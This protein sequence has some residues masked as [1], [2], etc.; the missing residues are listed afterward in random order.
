M[1][2]FLSVFSCKAFYNKLIDS[3]KCIEVWARTKHNDGFY[4]YKTVE[5][6]NKHI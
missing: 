3:L 4:L 6:N 1:I 5:R 2:R